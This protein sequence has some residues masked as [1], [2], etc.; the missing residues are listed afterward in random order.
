MKTILSFPVIPGLMLMSLF[1]FNLPVSAQIRDSQSFD[2][3]MPWMK[4]ETQK[5]SVWDQVPEHYRRNNAFRRMEWFYR[6]RMNDAGIF[7]SELLAEIKRAELLKSKEKSGVKQDSAYQWKNL[8]PSGIDFSHDYMAPHWG[9]VS[10]RIRGLAIHPSDPDIIYAGAGGGGVWKSTDGGN[11]WTDKSG[12]LNMITFGAIA[13]DPGNPEVIYAGTGEYSWQLTERFYYGD[14]LYKSIDG[15]NNWVRAGAEFGTV[16]HF[17]D[18]QVS[19]IHSE[20]VIAAIAGNLQGASPNEGVWLSRNSGSE[21]TRVLPSIGVFDVAF[22]PSNP[23]IVY[24]ACGNHQPM[25]GFLISRDGGITFTQ[26]NYGLPESNRIGRIQ[27]DIALSSPDVIFAVIFDTAFSADGIHTKLYRSENGGTS[28]NQ[29][30]QGVNLTPGGDQGFYDLCIAVSPVDPNLILIGNVELARSTDGQTFTQVRNP[31]G[32]G[33]GSDLF[34]SYTHL[35][36]HII[37]FAPSNPTTIYVGCDGGMFRSKDSGNTF[38]SVNKNI[39]SIQ[40]YRV[41]SHKTNPDIIYSGAQDNGFISTHD[42]GAT[43]FK[44]EFLGDGTECFMDYSNT[45]NIYFATYGGYF[46]G[47]FDGGTIWNLLVDPGTLDSSAFICPYWQHPVI[48][49]TI[50]G[51]LKQKLYK[52][53]DQGVHWTFTTQTAITGS[54]IETAAQSPVNPGKMMVAARSGAQRLSASSDGGYQ[55]QE[56]TGNLGV[57]ADGN[58]MRLIADPKDENTFYLLKIAYAGS[59]IL[60]TSNFGTDWVDISS[61]LPKV[62]SNDLFIDP[63]NEGVLYLGNDFGVYRSV[64]GGKGWERMNDGM[65]FVPVLD[66]DYYEANGERLL[67]AATFGRGVFELDLFP[68]QS[69][70]QGLAK[71]SKLL[72]RPN[73]ASSI[74][75]IDTQDIGFESGKITILSVT[76]EMVTNVVFIPANNQGTV[77]MDIT[78]LKPGVYELLLSTNRIIRSGKLVIVR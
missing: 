48:P 78:G 33:G 15:G 74:V 46:G 69:A 62:P 39:V 56:I 51:C 6:P 41:A 67:R 24:A 2:F 71:N 63:R 54:P 36:H 43:P 19:P 50:Y 3:V 44:L 37:R 47:T 26:S 77:S 55:W 5:T 40:S 31:A 28:W 16:T 10:G 38:Q 32:P 76:G 72:F 17:T 14:G 57:N 29:I 23:D 68:S 22:H 64:N 66:F 25:A 53:T 9:V 27:F 7:P 75:Y 18:L 13:I 65:P 45:Q 11:S 4:S 42:R 1:M 61:D 8:G 49:G 59:T 20:T 60:K 73:P 34:D 58:I 21:W 52:S 35:D 30:A 70:D 12:G